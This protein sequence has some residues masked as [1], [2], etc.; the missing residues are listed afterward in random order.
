MDG[1]DG[2]VT[3][4]MIIYLLFFTITINSPLVPLLA[5]LTSFIIFNW[6]PSKVFMGDVG[7]TFLGALFAGLVIQ[8]PTWIQSGESLLI[9][10]P[11]LADALI[12]VIRRFIN[13]ENIFNPHRKHLYQRLIGQRELTHSKVSLMYICAS[14]IIILSLYFGGIYFLIL[15]AFLMLLLGIYLDKVIAKPFKSTPYLID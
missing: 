4:S 11:V 10:T 2:L 15:S 7:S 8:M 1:I 6:H 3:G 12:C 9:A 14:I 5:C 13:K